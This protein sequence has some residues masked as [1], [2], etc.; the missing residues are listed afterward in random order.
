[1]AKQ[2]LL[3]VA[4]ILGGSV[5]FA[6]CSSVSVNDGSG[7]EAGEAGDNGQSGSPTSDAGSKGDAG[8]T[9]EGGD[10]TVADVDPAVLN[11]V[12]AIVPFAGPTTF[13]H[14]LVGVSDYGKPGEGTGEVVSLTIGTGKILG[15]DTYADGDVIAVGSAGVSFA[16]ERGNDKVNLL[17]AGKI[18]TTFDLKDKGTDTAPVD[19]KA[20][21]PLLN[22]SAIAILDLAEG[23]VS[24][25][26][27]LSE[28]QDAADKDGSVEVAEGVYEPKS[29]IV[30]F[31][32][33]RINLLS[34]DKD[35]HLPCSTTT[36]LVV[37]IDATT[38]KQV[39]L[40][41]KAAGKAIELKLANPRS[42]S[43]NADG[44]TLYLL[45]DGCYVGAKPK[46]RGV[47]VVDLPT[48]ATT[49]AYEDASTEYLS[50]MILTSGSEALIKT[51]DGMF[52][53][54]WR[55]LDIA[56]GTLTGELMNVPSSPTFD[57]KDLLGV[58]V[59]GT[60]GAVVR[61]KLAT[62]TSTVISATSWAGK[63]M[64]TPST[65]LVE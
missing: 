52:T 9:G 65:A 57:G 14:L 20:Y 64:S 7:G 41:G 29:N 26:I 30:Y 25:R 8:N 40:N 33:Q 48:A 24:R 1:M 44:D 6:A 3:A 59:T 15:S 42:L 34:F 53:T 45:A 63:Y 46:L 50:S 4:L 31:L 49:V 58:D 37:G 12:G 62:Q 35:F 61:Y 32:L 43:V 60:V 22:K 17:D 47:E 55:K 13:T 54:H 27:D 5:M 36:A 19:N 51:S 11:P 10:M 38:D 23:K 18:S 2:H 21:V 16:I 39:D 56:S 28:Y